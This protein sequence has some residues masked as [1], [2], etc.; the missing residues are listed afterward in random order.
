M[1]EPEIILS[2]VCVKCGSHFDARKPRRG[3]LPSVCKPC[4]AEN[5]RQAV[6]NWHAVHKNEVRA[7][8]KVRYE[9]QREQLGIKTREEEWARR[10]ALATRRNC[11]HCNK[12]FLL[13]RRTSQGRNRGVFC[14]KPCLAKA[15][16]DPVAAD[17]KMYARWAKRAKAA[18]KLSVVIPARTCGCGTEIPKYARRCEP[19]RETHSRNMKKAAKR[20]DKGRGLKRADKARRR[21]L[22]RGDGS[23]R[24][25]PVEIFK[26]DGWRCHLCQR[27]TP[28]KLLGTNDPLAPTV[29]HIIPLA[30][31]GKHTRINCACACRICNS[32]KSDRPLGQL[33]LVA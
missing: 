21:A 14:S 9:K 2:W 10:K 20:T 33:R 31:G 8:W 12:E 17:R 6:R 4:I 24:F 1:A 32:I 26:R 22:K 29:D 13:G 30:C 3:R 19:C 7:A 11:A 18:L 25:D 15:Q 16:R 5:S 27:K 28:E 23:E